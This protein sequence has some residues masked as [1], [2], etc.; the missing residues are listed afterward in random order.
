MTEVLTERDLRALMAVVEEGR[1]DQPTDGLPWAV[2]AEL[3]GV[4][5][6][7]AVTFTEG[8]LIHHRSL[9]DQNFEEGQRWF[10]PPA[11]PFSAEMW[12]NFTNFLPFRYGGCTGNQDG[13]VRWSDF[14]SL[15]ELREQ[16]LFAEF[17]RPFGCRHSI[18]LSLPTAPGRHRKI[19]LWRDTGS[20][21]TERDRLVL[22]L[23]QPHLYDVFLDA[24]RRQQRI[25]KLSPREWEVLQ[26]AGQ[27]HG[28]ADIARELFISVATVRK[29]L[30]HIY[31]RTG[32]RTR[33][34][35]AALMMPHFAATRT[36]RGQ[37]R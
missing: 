2:L 23:L 36:D 33:A 20:D 29:H 28:N 24:R 22:L 12:K 25:P 34:A 26:L 10:D 16:P 32:E 3:A 27:G 30:E 6:C 5:R 11:E 35:A 8:D 21:F 17:F 1:R 15:R 7:D 18:G 37:G 31:D 9:F 4:I 13:V 14:Y 19:S